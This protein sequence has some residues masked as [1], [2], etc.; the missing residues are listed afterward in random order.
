M[1]TAVV[2]A[3]GMG[4]R[5]WPRS[6]RDSPKQFLRLVG[7]K[8]LLEDTVERLQ[9]L[10]PPQQVLVVTSEAHVG[11]VRELLPGIPADNV[12]GE[13]MGRDTA[14][15]V[16]LAAILVHARD[17]DAV[18][19]AMPADH[20]IR[21][22]QKLHQVLKAAAEAARRSEALLV[23][24][25]KPRYPGTGYGY[26]QRG[27]KVSDIRGVSV[28]RVKRFVEK[29]K[30]EVARQ[31]VRSDGYY[32]NSGIFMWR[33]STILSAI[34][35]FLPDL[36]ASLMRI[37]K[38]L[39][40]GNLPEF[41]RG[42]YSKLA[43]IS[44]DYAVLEKAE[45]IWMIEADYEWDDVGSWTSMEEFLSKNR[46]GNVILGQHCGLDTKRSIILTDDH[47]IAT[48]GVSDLVV[49]RSPDATLICHRD[50]AQDIKQLL[51][52]MGKAGLQ[53]YL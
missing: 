3:G 12:I 50:R 15:C 51:E 20:Y 31:F 6:R 24:G 13:P 32:W 4:T 34:E 21:P 30:A 10:V 42:E 33:V 17:P 5:F 46:D 49:I 41:A 18:M 43:K 39:V 36:Y 48:L 11:K 22:R 35:R 40:G 28:Y 7:G 52:A 47:L 44:I 53:K 45:E 8:T 38:D 2:M 14:A 26:I 29:P 25:V 27:D 37:R 1:F 19:A 23:F 9:N 16:G